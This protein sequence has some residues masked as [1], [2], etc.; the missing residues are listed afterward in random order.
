MPHIHEKIDYAA[1]IYIVNDNA[2]LLRMHEKYGT[3][4]PPGGHVEL[5]ED[6]VEA[7]LREAKEETGLDVKIIGMTTDP[8][9]ENETNFKVHDER[10]VLVPRFIN[11]HRINDSHE[12]ISLEY[13]GRCETRDINPAPGEK[14]DGFKW[15]SDTELED[16]QFE[17]TDRVQLY[18]KAALKAARE[19]S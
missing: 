7:A 6:F 19:E 8:L 12:H 18:A 5:D 10:E 2:V 9:A 13:F 3:W 17:V 14:T 1:D 11:R 4:F 15:F 16:S